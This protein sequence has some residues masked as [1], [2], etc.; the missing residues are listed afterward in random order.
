MF[1]CFLSDLTHRDEALFIA[2]PDYTYKTRLKEEVIHFHGDEF[3][4]P[5]PCRIEG[6]QDS[7][8]SY[9]CAASL[10][11]LAQYLFDFCCIQNFGQ[12]VSLSEVLNTAEI[13][14]I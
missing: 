8:V 2:F 9:P 3:T 13:E 14:K 7:V 5:H 12:L 11:R 4:N 10:V 6:F 1:N